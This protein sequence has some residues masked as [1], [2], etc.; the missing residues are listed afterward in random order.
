MLKLLVEKCICFRA[1]ENPEFPLTIQIGAEPCIQAFWR[2]NIF[3]FCIRSAGQP[4]IG[5]HFIWNRER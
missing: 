5:P 4:Q 2:I 1:G 3:L